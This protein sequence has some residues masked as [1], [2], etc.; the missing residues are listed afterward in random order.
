MAQLLVGTHV[1]RNFAG[2]KGIGMPIGGC[3]C[4]GDA[5]VMPVVRA[6]ALSA[7]RARSDEEL[8]ASWLDSL[9][10]AHS[11]RNFAHDSAALPRALPMGLRAASG[12]LH[13]RPGSSSGLKLDP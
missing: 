2:I 4:H 13:A 3:R 11:R 1:A 10:S 5:L 8:V 7:T 9:R 6:E 12:Y